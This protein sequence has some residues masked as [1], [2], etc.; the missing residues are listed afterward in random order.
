MPSFPILKTGAVAQYPAERQI[1][2]STQVLEF[3]DGNEQRFREYRQAIRRWVIRLDLLDEGEF[4]A[5]AEFFDQGDPASP[6][7]FTDPWEGT[8]YPSCVI[9]GDE[10]QG[11]FLSG[12]RVK[13]E[14]KIKES[15]T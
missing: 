10:L 11:Q 7:S 6:F 12:A 1:I 2:F 4:Q 15:R 8:V 5:I 14:L 13:T 9:E 3:I